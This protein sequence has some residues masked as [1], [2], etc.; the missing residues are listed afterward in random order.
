[1][2]Q[3]FLRA[4]GQIT[5]VDDFPLSSTR[6]TSQYGRMFAKLSGTIDDVT[7]SHIVLDVNGVGYLVAA[8]GR[9]LGAIGKAGARATLWIETIVR[10]DAIAL[11][12]FADKA[13]QAWFRLLTTVQGVGAKVALSILSTLAADQLVRAIS[14]G[15]KS[16]LSQADGV[17]PK[18]AVR[19]VT[20]LKDKAA[21][22]A[23][24][25]GASG[26]LGSVSLRAVPGDDSGDAAG[27]V[28][29]LIN[30]GY[31][32]A[33]A[34]E[35]V[36]TVMSRTGAVPGLGDLIRLSLGELAA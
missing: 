23:V 19:L 35:A 16:I 34:A 36:A 21:A 30:L 1:M 7:A 18:L 9:T 20:E 6:K 14:M 17:G 22:L 25:G 29:A 33:E 24:A 4:H 13:E 11:Y 2:P 27:A 8:S 12:G 26:A 28:S 31:R 5:N 15:D 3:L 10:E 32:R